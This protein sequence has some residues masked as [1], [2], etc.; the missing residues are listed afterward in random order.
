MFSHIPYKSSHV[1]VDY[2]EIVDI[3]DL[4]ENGEIIVTG[5][6]NVQMEIDSFSDEVNI[7]TIIKN[8]VDPSSLSVIGID[9]MVD[10]SILPKDFNSAHNYV[11]E[12][13]DTAL[14]IYD[15]LSEVDKKKFS[16]FGDF[17]SNFENFYN[18]KINET[19]TN[20]NNSQEAS[21]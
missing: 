12:K 14:K 18:A 10:D 15:N 2:P 7:N 1:S 9:T 16:S 6:H 13:F 8:C 3:L 4:D 19:N 17:M 11:A 20:T 21:E 5:T